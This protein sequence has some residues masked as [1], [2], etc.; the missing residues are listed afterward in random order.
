MPSSMMLADRDPNGSGRTSRASNLSAMSKATGHQPY[1]AGKPDLLSSAGPSIMS[2]LRTSTEMGNVVGLTGDISGAG[3]FA[4]APQRR[5]ASSRLSTASSLSNNSS[6]ASR[7]HRQWPSSSSAARHSMARE[8]QYIA[9][10]LSPTM[11]NIPGSP[12][13][14]SR[15]R[16]RD[17]HRSLSMTHAIQP[18]YRLSSNRSLGS[19]RHEQLQRPKSPWAYPTRLR[20][21]SYRPES[22][23]L[24]DTT[25]SH[26][27]RAHGYGSQGQP[28][29]PSQYVGQYPGQG[30]L[31]LP[32]DASLGQQD[33]APGMPRRPSRGPSP[34][35]H[36]GHRQ[37]MP[38]MPSNYQHHI[39]V[40]QARMLNRSVKG[41]MSSGSTNLRTDSDA[42]SS[43]MAFPPTPKDGASME[44][45]YAHDGTRHFVDGVTSLVKDQYYSQPRYYDGSEVFE[46]EQFAEPEANTFQTGIVTRIKTIVEERGPFEPMPKRLAPSGAKI[47]VELARSEVPGIVELPASPVPRRITREIVLKGLEPSSTIEELELSIQ[48]PV[49]NSDFA[50]VDS[51]DLPVANRLPNEGSVELSLHPKDGQGSRHSMLS[52]TGSSVLE[53]STLDF[54]VRYSIPM[55]TGAGFGIDVATESGN[56]PLPPT[57]PDRSTADGMSELLAGYQHTESK[58]GSNAMSQGE[59][60]PKRRTIM[61]DQIERKSNHAPRSSG[62]QSFKSCTDLPEAVSEPGSPRPDK[63]DDADSVISV[64]KPQAQ[65]VKEADARSF[66][67][68]KDA[69]TPDRATSLP[70]SR[71]PSAILAAGVSLY[72]RPVSET[73]LSS[74][75]SAVLP[76]QP[77]APFRESSFSMVASKLRASSTPSVKQASVSTSVSSSMLSGVQQPPAVP[78]R[79]SSSSKEAQRYQAVASFLMRQLPS[80]RAKSWKQ[81]KDEDMPRSGEKEQLAWDS[82]PAKQEPSDISSSSELPLGV[83][84]TPEKALVK[85]NVLLGKQASASIPT[86][87]CNSPQVLGLGATP[88]TRHSSFSSPCPVI[89]AASSVYSPH[90]I[91]FK[92]HVYSSSPAG[93]PGGQERSQRDSQTTTHLVWP[94]RKYHSRRSASFGEAH[95]SLPDIQ[96]NTTTDLRLSG[97]GYKY[98]VPSQYLPELKEES[99]EN[100][101]LNTSTSN[102]NNLSFR[103][104]LGGP[105]VARASV[106]DA[107]MYSRRSSTTSHRQSAVGSALGQTRG[108]PSMH[109]SRM[110]LFEN[111]SDEL[112]LRNS[113]S[114]DVMKESE[115]LSDGNS[116]RPVSA[117]EVRERFRSLVADLKSCE[118]AGR[119]AQSTKATKPVV[120]WRTRSPEEV[121][122]EIEQLTIP[123][124]GGLTQRFTEIFPSLR[125]YYKLGEQPKFIEEET[126]MEHALEQIHEVAPAQK[127]SSARLRPVPGSPNM[128]VIDDAVYEELTGKDREGGSSNQVG[129]GA[130]DLSAGRA[131]QG[132]DAIQNSKN[133]TRSHTR[134]NSHLLRLQPPSPARLRPR[135][136]TV[137]HQDFRTSADS[138][139]TSSRSLRSF[140][141]TPTTT[142]TRPWNSDKNYPWATSTIPSV[143]IALPAP[144]A[145]R[146]SPRPGPSHLRNRLSGVSTTSSFSSAQTATGSPF[147]SPADSNAHAR[148]HR[149][150]VFGKHGDRPHA[151]GERY[152]TSALTPPTAIFRD[153]F[154]ASDISDDEYFAASRKSKHGLR[155]R[156]S[157]AARN[158]TLDQSTRLA[159][160]KTNPQDL[161]SPESSNQT[162]PSVLPGSTGEAEAPA[163]NR[164]TFRNA[165][166]MSAAEFHRGR[167]VQ[168]VKGWWHKS[169]EFVRNISTRKKPTYCDF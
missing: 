117:G 157:T 66:R 90:D 149:F 64:S 121:M 151:V 147:G 106:D 1:G 124:V 24:S 13:S 128:I 101:S 75:P 74:P 48:S 68:A 163:F 109:F 168:R 30:R 86:M 27:R 99:H 127:R 37:D 111:L 25:G 165:E 91:S 21:P 11:I 98:A 2:M 29:Y 52:Q 9:D 119:S 70:S 132:T 92:P 58:A 12:Q 41:S 82:T 73:P 166:G 146:S 150:S 130:S 141:S 55:A 105:A 56:V 129:D 15:P 93:L 33:R 104:P 100:S 53:S 153:H 107:V 50:T 76:K 8:P 28:Y 31:R 123:S 156:F 6:R 145:V 102:L 44:V 42:P 97:Y 19:L 39:A 112:G 72:N 83:V 40:E 46:R 88:S 61:E 162:A 169:T 22:P 80:R 59:T 114:V 137:G 140:A 4:R 57:S 34:V 36:S 154:S 17:S 77:P 69:V 110:N 115:I 135:S 20:R 113:R 103:F 23:A 10:T 63:E 126:I 87:D 18:T 120:S 26:S 125:D 62:A 155:K 67:T 138:A 65:S 108:L 32:S 43:D 85:Q 7:H 89:P 142:E 14:G 60:T 71:L 79:E 158:V 143:D 84:M 35:F 167:I 144:A 118:Q 95:V 134:Q 38:P 45:L 148:H 54:A 122:A 133:V 94:G 81:T 5:G 3:S 160:S 164:H 47:S 16:D 159:R 131:G 51:D 49:R 152:P 78:P 139:L 136:Q 161:A 116:R 96:E